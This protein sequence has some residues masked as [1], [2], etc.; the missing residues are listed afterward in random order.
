M[1][2]IV[3]FVSLLSFSFGYAQG[4]PIDFEGDVTAEN[5]E[6]FD[7]GAAD[8][9]QNPQPD[10]INSSAN[11]GVIVRDGGAIWSG[12]KIALTE[13]L[14][15]SVLTV[16]TMKVYTTAPAGTTV[17]LKLEG[18][19]P[20][21]EVDAITTTTSEWETLEFIFV[22]T[23]DH[24]NELVFMFDFGNT[25]DGS[26]N[27]TFY[28]DDIEQVAGPPAPIPAALPLDFESGTVSSD[29]LD[30][31]GATVDV[32]ANP[33]VDAANPSN[34]VGR[35]IRDGGE[36]WAGSQ[37]L[38]AQDL[39]LS[40][41]WHIA[42]KVY[43]TAPIGTRIKV[44]LQGPDGSTN[45][46]Y[47]TTT[48][49]EWETATWNFYGQ[50]G[51]YNRILFMFDYGNTGDGSPSSAF[52]FDDVAQ[53]EG[54]AL[55]SPEPTSLP[56]DFEEGEVTTDFTNFFGAFTDVIPNPQADDSN[57]SATVARFVRS[58]GAPW[59]Q[60]KLTLT[61]FID[62]SELSFISA[63][64]YTDAP[65]GTLLKLKVESTEAGFAN[66]K[67]VYTTVSG[68]WAT[69]SWDFTTGDPPIY[70]VI[71]P[72]F[73]YGTVN[74]ASPEATF[75]FDDIQLTNGTLNTNRSAEITGISCFPNPAKDQV[76]VSSA[77]DGIVQIAVFDVLGNQ[78]ANLRPNALNTT[79]DVS[80][81]ARGLYILQISTAEETTGLK[82]VVD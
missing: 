42:M 32:I 7:G 2:Q 50:D 76:T 35:M 1:K 43:V 36:F 45:L 25:G 47:L 6:N 53:Q 38:L 79:V 4:L 5:F 82:L 72:M 59:A 70:N 63:K 29:F 78:V 20:F 17:K 46:D 60:S 22:G 58:G 8:V 15:F 12:S 48:S 44:E 9:V 40:T 24:L 19:L 31:S 28:F 23:G 55:A 67:D 52:L 33:Q 80:G 77:I 81:F 51:N 57:P 27:S 16:I 11:V 37:I 56:V 65:V 34:T 68:A 13:N 54:P 75:L 21:A 39:D 64:V 26:E 10:G 18:E 61:D 30:F 73:G 62:F 14:D 74:N 66:E 41:Q 3:F 49:G 69:Y 71:T